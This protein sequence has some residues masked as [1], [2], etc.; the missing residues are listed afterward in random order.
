M[1]QF[2]ENQVVRNEYSTIPYMWIRSENPN[3]SICVMLPGLGYSTQ[4]PLFHYATGV[5]LNNHVDVLHINYDFAKNEH[6]KK[7]TRSEQDRWMY[8]DVKAVVDEVLKDSTYEQCILLS[9]SIGTIPMAIEW[10]E[11]NFSHNAFGIWLTPLLKD[12]NVFNTLLNTE[13][14]SLCVIG[15]QDHHFIEE[16]ISSFKKNE[17]VSSVLIPN[18]DHGL[19]I[20]GDIVASIDAVKEV[21]A[22]VQEFIVKFTKG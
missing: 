19:E 21:M 16:R 4:R 22:S 20:K 12:D 8:E 3:K 18:A 7:L 13:L 9:K 11:K 2:T 15:D 17:L 14:P 1:Y 5:C 10:T 6:F